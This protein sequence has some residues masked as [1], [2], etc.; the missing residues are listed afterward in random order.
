MAQTPRYQ[1]TLR[2][3]AMIEESF[4]ED[5]AGLGFDLAATSTLDPKTAM[6]SG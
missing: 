4:I 5:E 1:E 2:K 6:L 3:L